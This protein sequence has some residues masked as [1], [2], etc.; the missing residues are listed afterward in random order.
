LPEGWQWDHRAWVAGALDGP[1]VILFE[2]DCTDE[3]DDRIRCQIVTN[4]LA[5]RRR[6][7]VCLCKQK[8]KAKGF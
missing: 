1:F 2:Q 8:E 5:Q 7:R 3:P 6:S 4:A